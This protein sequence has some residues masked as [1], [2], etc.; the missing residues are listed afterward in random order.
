VN[1][2]T[3]EWVPNENFEKGNYKVEVYHMGYNIGSENVTLK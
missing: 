3:T 2:I 1:D